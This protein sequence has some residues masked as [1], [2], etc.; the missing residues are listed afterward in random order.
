M[1]YRVLLYYKYVTITDYESFADE[2][3]A[4]CKK[5]GVLGRIIVAEEGIN[6]TI[7][8][9]IEQTNEYIREMRTDTRFED[10]WFKIDEVPA[11]TFEKMHVRAK[12]EIVTWRFE[13]DIDPTETTGV[14][15]NPQQFY[16]A[17]QN[18]DVLIIDGRNDYEY[19]LGHFRGAIRPD[20]R[21][22]REFPEWIRENLSAYKDKKILTYCTGGIR[23]EKLSGF[24]V[25]EGFQD[26]SQL[27]GGIVTYAKDETVRGRGFDGKCYVFDAR[28]SVPVS[29]EESVIVSTC[30]HCGTPT[31]RYV[32]CGSMDCHK[33]H[34]SC[35][36]CEEKHHRSCSPECEAKPKARHRWYQEHDVEPEV[37]SPVTSAL[38]LDAEGV[39]M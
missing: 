18:D 20:V 21:N 23:C 30:Y 10:M 19:D 16:D 5:L 4:Y 3:L 33:Q 7:S 2:H 31:A 13:E 38:K 1:P 22:S 28:I 17:M 15:L 27:H 25:K 12:N 24:L 11:H 8:G 6:G 9:T 14:Y 35:E 26:V 36:A 29:Q 39:L 37:K 32:N 34:F